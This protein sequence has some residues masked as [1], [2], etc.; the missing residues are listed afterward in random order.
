MIKY[1]SIKSALRFVPKP[2]FNH[3]DELDFLSWM[4]DA[5]RMLDLP[6]TMENKIQIFEIENGKV[7]LPDDLKEIN[8]ITY[9]DTNPSQSDTDSFVDCICN[10]ES[11]ANT[12]DTNNPCQY[13]LAYKQFLDSPYY[14]NNY[15]PLKFIGNYGTSLL[16]SD[17]PNRFCSECNNVFSI[18]KNRNIRTNIDSGFLCIDYATEMTNDSGEYLIQDLTELKQYLAYYAVAKHWEERASIRETGADKSAQEY[19]SKAEIFFKKC[20][21]ILIMRGINP[22][23]VSEAQYDNYQKLLQIPEKYVYSR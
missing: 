14:Q 17:C 9:M 10:A 3:S 8:S 19:L 5:Y 6:V 7:S 16:C 1:V 20:R 15:K 18:D 4:L 11:N 22:T 12:E 2:L 23:A 13:T 21:S